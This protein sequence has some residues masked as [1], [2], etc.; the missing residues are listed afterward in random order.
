MSAARQHP[1]TREL[2][3]EKLG[4]LGGTVHELER[5]EAEI[6]GGPMVPMSVLGKVRARLKEL[7]DAA[8]VALPPRRIAPPSVLQRLR[9][10]NRAEL[11]RPLT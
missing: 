3:E 7:L 6:V 5:L 11:G 8:G 9:A 1:I 4:R 2:L 10:E